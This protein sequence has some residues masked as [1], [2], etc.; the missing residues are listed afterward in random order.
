M[1][2]GGTVLRS[3]VLNSLSV[4]AV[5]VNSNNG[6]V[7]LRVSALKD[8]IVGVLLIVESI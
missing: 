6:V 5:D 7:E 8:F 4:V 3:D 1:T 2:K